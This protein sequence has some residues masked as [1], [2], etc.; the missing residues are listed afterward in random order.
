MDPKDM[1]K[2][3]SEGGGDPPY[4]WSVEIVKPAMREAKKE[5]QGEEYLHIQDQIR[6]LARC[7]DPTKPE[8]LSVDAVE[9]FHELREKGG[10]LG[11]KNVRVFFTTIAKQ[12]LMIL[13]VY[14]K[15]ADGGTPQHI[16]IKIGRRLS[17]VSSARKKSS[18]GS[19]R[20]Q[21]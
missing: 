10:P 6:E 5:L 2:V 18:V 12:T 13:G 21:S 20:K 19:E 4:R 14:K 15:E 1:R 7:E 11:R 17:E 8:T 16:K 9:G 3:I